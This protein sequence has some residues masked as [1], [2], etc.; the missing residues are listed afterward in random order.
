MDEAV[1][2]NRSARDLHPVD[3]A[4]LIAAAGEIGDAEHG[5]VLTLPV[6]HDG[7]PVSVRVHTHSDLARFPGVILEVLPAAVRRRAP[8]RDHDGPL[9][10]LV[11]TSTAWIAFCATA[12]RAADAGVSV[13]IAGEAGSGK[14]AVA[15]AV[16]DLAGRSRFAV[17]DA[18]S[19]LAD[20][21]P[22]W[23]LQL[24]DVLADAETTVVVRHLERC[25]DAL[26][27][28]AAAEI[29]AAPD[30]GRRLFATLDP[31]MLSE[32]VRPL[33]DR[34]C[35][36]LVVPPLRD[37]RDDTELLVR[38]LLERHG[39]G[40]RLRFHPQAIAVLRAADF[41][42]N[43]RGLEA[44][45]AGIA[46]TRRS[47]DVLAGDLPELRPAGPA[48]LTPME[49]AERDA[50]VKAL[51]EANQN[52]AASAAALGISRPT[53]YRKLSIYGIDG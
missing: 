25:D 52:K 11:G 40:S 28:A 42:G 51:H 32:A 39:A 41:P 34:F 29:D 38:S 10:A 33:L 20:G 14:L 16:H 23:L 15:R 36:R 8:R 24:R 7:E 2:L 50:I 26:A 6:H 31:T 37:R 12:R 30:A 45:V 46:R 4:A 1:L 53:L 9:P 13:A 44:V 35:V 49:R 22:A 18:A 47:G 19:A 27:A 21:R 43:V 48:H 3:Q 17:I 5:A